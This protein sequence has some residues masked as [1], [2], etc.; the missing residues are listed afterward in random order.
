[1][2]S[3]HCQLHR[4][5]HIPLHDFAILTTTHHELLVEPTQITSDQK[6]LLMMSLE[7]IHYL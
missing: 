7:P 3:N 4:I 5:S 2:S 1:M 6:L